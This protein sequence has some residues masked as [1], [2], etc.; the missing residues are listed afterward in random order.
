MYLK[1]RPDVQ[2]LKGLTLEVK[3]GETVAL[4]GQSGCG[5][6]TCIQLI[7]RFYD[8]NSGSIE[9][10]GIPINQLNLSWL[11]TDLIYGFNIPI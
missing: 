2:V 7:Q 1:H 6:S 10:D 8:G 11:R 4:V 3:K 9:L 5:K